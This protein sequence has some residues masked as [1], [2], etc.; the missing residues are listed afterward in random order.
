MENVITGKLIKFVVLS[1]CLTPFYFVFEP[2]VRTY[3]ERARLLCN[4]NHFSSVT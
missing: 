2:N 3:K 1:P 4:G